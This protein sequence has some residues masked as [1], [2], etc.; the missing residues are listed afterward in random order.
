MEETL[1][2]EGIGHIK[3]FRKDE[4]V[5]IEKEAGSSMFIVLDGAFGV[6]INSF[7]DFPLKIDTVKKGSFFGELSVINGTVRN[8]TVISERDSEVIVV[9]KEVFER[10]L[11][12][13]PVIAAKVFNT[14]RERAVKVTKAVKNLG[15][16]VPDMPPHLLTAQFDGVKKSMV[17][18]KML[19]I[20]FHKMSEMLIAHSRN[21]NGRAPLIEG[22]TLKL[23]PEGY[24]KYNL[25]ESKHDRQFLE[26]KI[27]ICPFCGEY[28]ISNI[29][30]LSALTHK[31]TLFDGRVIYK[32]FDILRYTNI[33]CP[34]CRY[35][36]S[37]HEFIAR[38]KPSE[39]NGFKFTNAENFTGYENEFN[40][41]VDEAV[42]SYYLN[43][44]C[45]KQV[46]NDS[47]RFA[48]S[49]IRLYWIF[50]DQKSASLAKQAAEK[51]RYYYA[52][53]LGEN[54]NSL[55]LENKMR[56]NMIL[57][58]LAITLDDYKQAA[59]YYKRNINIGNSVNNELYRDSRHRYNI[60][61]T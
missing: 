29:P 49:W 38:K 20:Q 8:A 10:M 14:L 42:L 9:E 33:V 43:I 23:L 51:A 27:A 16:E 54:E 28:F 60:L 61:C 17:Y 40:H 25:K 53:F 2:R 3:T 47:L 5:Y 15:K 35:T 11:E 26:E 39:Y 1:V 4:T 31:R 30:M 45:L 37:Y 55:P 59:E 13:S 58:E 44:E 18:L 22:H 34:N 6:Y 21:K 36:D 32:G 7:F 46:T 50:S 52:D 56:I 41:T 19:A 12:I 57:G 24:V 48:N